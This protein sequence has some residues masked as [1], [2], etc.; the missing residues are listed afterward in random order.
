MSQVWDED[1]K[2]CP[3][4]VI[5]VGTNVVTQ[6]K[7]DEKDGYSAVQVG[8][9]SRNPK[10]ISK[11]ATLNIFVCLLIMVLKFLGERTLNPQRL[12]V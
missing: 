8:W 9:G 3:V 12:M 11:K 4:T 7:T 1:G 10:N 5:A 6:V 2:V